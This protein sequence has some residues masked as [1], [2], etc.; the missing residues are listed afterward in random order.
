MIKDNCVEGDLVAQLD[1][2][3]TGRPETK[4]RVEPTEM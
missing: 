4:G 2:P 1:K 3:S